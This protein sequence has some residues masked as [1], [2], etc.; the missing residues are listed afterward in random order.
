MEKFSDEQKMF[1]TG[2]FGTTSSPAKIRRLFLQ[3]YKIFGR[4]LQFK[5]FY[6]TRINKNFEKNGTI[7][8]NNES[9]CPTKRTPEKV[10]KVRTFVDGKIKK[11]SQ[12]ISASFRHFYNYILKNP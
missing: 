12:E 10:E 6:F 8:R 1:I 11:L 5:L 9:E 2:T 7:F 3:A 4:A